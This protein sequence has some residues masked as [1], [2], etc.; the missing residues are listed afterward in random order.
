MPLLQI[1]KKKAKNQRRSVI[2][3]LTLF[4]KDIVV[5][6]LRKEKYVKITVHLL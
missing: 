4:K 2:L 3:K 1:Y 5:G 6:L